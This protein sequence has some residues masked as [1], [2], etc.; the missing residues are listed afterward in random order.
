MPQPE[1]GIPSCGRMAGISPLVVCSSAMIT[2]CTC[3]MEQ[4]R[5]GGEECKALLPKN[6]NPDISIGRVCKMSAAF[7]SS[8]HSNRTLSYVQ[9]TT[10]RAK[11]HS[12]NMS[13]YLKCSG[14]PH[15]PVFPQK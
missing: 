13:K 8:Q 9:N 4:K 5:C 11:I 1:R 15:N 12:Q 2:P 6:L 7:T 14:N 10:V 3:A